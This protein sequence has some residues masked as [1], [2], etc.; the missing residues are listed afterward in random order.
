MTFMDLVS[1]ISLV[2]SAA[3]FAT[4]SAQK[5]AKHKQQFIAVGFVLFGF[6]I[7]RVLYTYLPPGSVGL[8]I[9]PRVLVL[10][11][12]VAVMAVVVLVALKKEGS[13]QAVWVVFI[14]LVYLNLYGKSL[15]L[16]DMITLRDKEILSAVEINERSRDFDRAIEIL[17][18]TRQ[19][20]SQDEQR[21]LDERIGVLR[22]QKAKEL[23]HQ[24][25]Q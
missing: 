23:A 10:A 11:M 1:L 2:L 15:G 8:S 24:Q 25:S 3:S 7:S 17:E 18:W 19:G 12:V 9:R 5:L 21:M 22:S 20:R 14:F 6:V 4:S 16:I 13:H